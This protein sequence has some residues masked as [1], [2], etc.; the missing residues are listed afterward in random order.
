MSAADVGLARPAERILAR[1]RLLDFACLVDQTYQ[2]APHSALIAEHLDALERKEIQRLAISCPPQHGKSRIT[3]Q[4]L[5]AWW[6][7]KRPR[8]SVVLAS[9]ASELANRNS[10]RARGFLSA[11]EYPF[12]SRVSAESSAVDRWETT[13]G[14]VCIAVGVQGGLTGWGS[15]LL[16]ADDLIKDRAAADSKAVRDAAWSWWT[17]VALTRTRP[18]SSIV[19]CG[20]RWSDDDV[21]GRALNSDGADAW[22]VLNLPAISEGEGDPLDRPE[23]DALWPEIYPRPWLDIQRRELGER[24]FVALYQGDPTPD[25]GVV[26]DREWLEGRYSTLPDR[27]LK[28]IQAVD[29]SFKTGA[30][31]DYSVIATW[32]SDR[33]FFYLLD[34][35]RK[36]VT[37]P[38]LIAAIKTQAAAYNPTA[39]LIEDSASGQSAL[40]TIKAETKLPVIPA[41]AKNS[42]VARAE[43]ISP[44]FE[45]GRVLLPEQSPPWLEPW[46]E[47]HVK[48][49]AGKHD[50]QVDTTSYALERLRGH[51]GPDV[52]PSGLVTPGGSTWSQMGG[53]GGRPRWTGM[54][55]GSL[56]A[57]KW[58]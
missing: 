25:K 46:I 50:D 42:K 33:Q 9:Y 27:G 52:A 49:P 41:A 53:G 10:R 22:T 23:G 17:E 29:S 45:S 28:I 15:D 43:N 8:E 55:G 35:W 44:L 40:Q 51:S 48:F 18:S 37:F 34:V 4:M 1:R 16:V 30:G 14:G 57:G 32:G 2:R 47:E 21:I 26:F 7:G 19:L 38:D 24:S 5:P 54:G 6:L 58:R 12:E 3:S 36:K 13:E 31:N 56:G 20:T 11:E 39:V